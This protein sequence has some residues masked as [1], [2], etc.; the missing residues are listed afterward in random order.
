MLRVRNRGQLREGVRVSM[1]REEEEEAVRVSGLSRMKPRL[2]PE[3]SGF[4]V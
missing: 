3:P 2:N 1:G 4:R